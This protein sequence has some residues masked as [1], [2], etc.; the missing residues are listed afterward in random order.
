MAYGPASMTTA[1]TTVGRPTTVPVTIVG[2]T[3]GREI[4]VPSSGTTTVG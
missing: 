2:T 3:T 1:F 4:G